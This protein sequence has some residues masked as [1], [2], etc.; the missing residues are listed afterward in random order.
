MCYPFSS[1]CDRV[2]STAYVFSVRTI[3]V[4]LFNGINSS[5]AVLCIE[6]LVCI[7]RIKNY[8]QSSK[9]V[10]VAVFLFGS[11][12]LCAIIFAALYLPGVKW[13]ERLAVP[14]LINS[15][16]AVNSQ[17]LTA[18]ILAIEFVGAFFFLFIHYWSLWYRKRIRGF[19]SVEHRSI[20]APIPLDQPLSVK[21]QIEETIQI[22]SLFLP[23]VLVREI[24]GLF[25]IFAR[26]VASTV[27]AF[28]KQ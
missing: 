26:I 20:A 27:S 11:T 28:I 17:V 18:Y 16:N 13:N 19:K 5:M 9:P 22:T 10:L 2:W 3:A 14:S 1:P 12:A 21:F 24:T 25:G 4:V 15:K 23:L 8:E 6:R 7:C